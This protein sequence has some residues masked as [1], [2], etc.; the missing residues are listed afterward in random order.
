MSGVAGVFGKSFSGIKPTDLDNTINQLSVCDTKVFTT[1][2]GFLTNAKNK[3]FT[4]DCSR[5]YE[6]YNYVCCLDGELIDHQSVPWESIINNIEREQFEFFKSFKSPFVIVVLNKKKGI[7]IIVSDR[8]S[9]QPMYY[10]TNV[11][12]MVISTSISTFCKLFNINNFNIHWLYEFLFFNYPIKKTT[13]FKNV[14]RMPPATVLKYDFYTNEYKLF[15]YAEKFKRKDDLLSGKNAFEKAKEVFSERVPKYFGDKMDVALGLSGGL[16]SRAILS[17][18]PTASKEYTK[19]YTF[20]IP[21]C[22][23]L[24]EASKITETLSLPHVEIYFDDIFEKKLPKLIY[25]TV[26]LS[27]GLQQVNRSHLTHVYRTLTNSG[28]KLSA[29]ITG[30]SGDHL[31]RD[32]IKGQGNIPVIINNDMMLILQTGKIDFNDEFYKYMFSKNSYNDFKEYIRNVLENLKLNHGKF[33]FGETYM[34]YLVYEAAPKYLGGDASLAN[35]FS[36]FRSPYWDSDIIQLS[37]DIEFST[38]GFSERLSKKDKYRECCLQAYLVQNNTQLSEIMYRGVPLKM[39]SNNN[40]FIF[41]IYR[42][43]KKVPKKFLTVLNE[44]SNPPFDNWGLWYNT[45][46][47]DEINK[48]ITKDSVICKYISWSFIKQLKEKANRQKLEKLDCL[49]LGKIATA[50]I[51]LKLIESGWKI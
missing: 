30:D 12:G 11:N 46:L 27:G 15:K 50:E 31:F 21:G 32:H 1:D 37:Y 40:K 49:F 48:L 38:M 9:L 4:D 2:F 41:N 17:F 51:V 33:N 34:D 22:S 10:L 3:F 24:F 35:N 42:L 28:K 43:A 45:A 23:D 36:N 16:D 5:S 8:I 26:Y 29:I 7:I 44:K 19:T 6:N 39:Y 13:I 20:G 25:E 18:I 14:V 47:N